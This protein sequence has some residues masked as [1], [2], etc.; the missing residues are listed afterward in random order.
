VTVRAALVVLAAALP[1]AASAQVQRTADY[2][3]KMDADHDGR[4]SLVEYQDWL[5]YAAPTRGAVTRP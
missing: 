2:L 1:C 4:V 5:S 3:S